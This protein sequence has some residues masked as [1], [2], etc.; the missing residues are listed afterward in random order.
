MHQQHARRRLLRMIA[1]GGLGAGGLSGWM[2]RALAS[3]DLPATPGINRLEGSVTINGKPAK[4]GTPVA[5]GDRVATGPNSQAVVVLKGDAFL[6]RQQTVI[7]VQGGRDGTLSELAIAAGRVLSVF[8][9]KPV[10]IKAS[11]ASIGIRGTGAYLEV[12]PKSVYFCLCYG[13]ALVEGAGMESKLVKTT[14][15]EQ[16]LMLRDQGGIMRVEPGPFQNHSDDELILLESLVG[17]EPPFTK[18]AQYPAKKY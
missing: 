10:S 5:M 12:E 8:A 14:H 17:R 2:S 9:K 16:P 18:D 11:V 13:E 4:V 3:G 1:A 15:H 6:L 7:V